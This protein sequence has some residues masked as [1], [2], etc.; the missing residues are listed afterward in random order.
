VVSGNEDVIE[1]HSVSM[2]V[3]G[4]PLKSFD[5]CGSPTL[6]LVSWEGFVSGLR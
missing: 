6:P 1:V 3:E 4:S 2:K 5:Y